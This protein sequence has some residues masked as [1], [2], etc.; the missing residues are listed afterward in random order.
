M[1]KEFPALKP[2]Q[3]YRGILVKYLFFCDKGHEYDQL[4]SNA[5][6]GNGCRFCTGQDGYTTIQMYKEFPALK[7]GQEY[8]GSLKNYCFLCD[9]GH[10]YEHRLANVRQGS[11]CR[12]CLC[13]YDPLVI[14]DVAPEVQEKLAALGVTPKYSFL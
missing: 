3:E 2:G 9:K 4:L 6:K 13:K 10:E 5:R 11:G 14:P 1:Y 12:L 7:P 8:R